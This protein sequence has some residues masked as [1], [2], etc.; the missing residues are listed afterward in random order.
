[1]FLPARD[2]LNALNIFYLQ[3]LASEIGSPHE[4]LVL[5]R[6]HWRTRAAAR[7]PHARRG[8]LPRGARIRRHHLSE[9][10]AHAVPVPAAP[11]QSDAALR[12]AARY[13]DGWIGRSYAWDEAAHYVTKLKRF[14]GDCGRAHGPFE[15][16]IGLHG[17]PGADFYRRAEEKLGIT[18]LLCRPWAGAEHNRAERNSPDQQ[19]PE[20][21]AE[22]YRA[23]INRFAEQV[24]ARC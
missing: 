24:V 18:G 22:R 4:V 20:E 9:G 11:G 1:M 7:R 2:S 15:I 10:L 5:D 19:H 21:S 17:E 3:G 16:I 14:L 6:V 8:R 23:A 13:G 12:R